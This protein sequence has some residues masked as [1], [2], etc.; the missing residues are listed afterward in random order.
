MEV[1]RT[2]FCSAIVCSATDGTARS[3]LVSMAQ[4]HSVLH[5][6]F[7]AAQVTA[8]AAAVCAAARTWFST[9]A[10]ACAEVQN[11]ASFVSFGNPAF[12]GLTSVVNQSAW[13]YGTTSWLVA[14]MRFQRRRRT[15]RTGSEC[16]CFEGILPARDRFP[17]ALGVRI[18]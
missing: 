1:V 12:R 3:F 8:T 5:G 16:Q 15:G 17:I 2:W 6:A 14:G 7:V 13:S 11:I 4:D 9:A 18:P 10:G